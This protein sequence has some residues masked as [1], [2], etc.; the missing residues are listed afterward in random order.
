MRAPLLLGVPTERSAVAAGEVCR[1]L[2]GIRVTVC[3]PT[4]AFVLVS[5]GIGFLGLLV[6]L[7]VA[8]RALWVPFVTF[9]FAAILGGSTRLKVALQLDQSLAGVLQGFLVL[10]V[11]LF[12]GVRQRLQGRATVT[13][14]TPA[15]AGFKPISTS[16]G[17]HP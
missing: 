9:A 17:D 4:A 14:D 2:A 6:V 1:A 10:V 12:N 3:L 8:N 16:V 7:L 5:G 15:G 13:E 11:L